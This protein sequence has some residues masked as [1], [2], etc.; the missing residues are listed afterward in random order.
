MTNDDRRLNELYRKSEAA[1]MARKDLTESLQKRGGLYADKNKL[2]VRP[3]I[4]PLQFKVDS[5]FAD[6][7]EFPL[8]HRLSQHLGSLDISHRPGSAHYIYVPVSLL[9][10]SSSHR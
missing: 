4:S 7:A 5:L 2:L 9:C 8:L 3:S 1:K 10:L 6:H